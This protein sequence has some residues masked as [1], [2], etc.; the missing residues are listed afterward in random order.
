MHDEEGPIGDLTSGRDLSAFNLAIKMAKS[1]V[2]V[3]EILER[4]DVSEDDLV[5]AAPRL[6]KRVQGLPD[7]FT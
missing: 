2:E 4:F 7:D 6:A 1:K 3:L 5:I